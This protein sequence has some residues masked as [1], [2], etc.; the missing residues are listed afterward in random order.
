MRVIL[1]LR[2]WHYCFMLSRVWIVFLFSIYITY[3]KQ[4]NN[5]HKNIKYFPN[6]FQRPPLPLTLGIFWTKIHRLLG[7]MPLCTPYMGVNLRGESP[8]YMNP[9]PSSDDGNESTSRRQG[10]YR[11][12]LS[13][14]SRSAKLGADGQKVILDIT[15]WD[16]ESH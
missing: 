11:E 10:R 4:R 6:L 16:M 3:G 12:V 7:S 14:E 1:K 5:E 2:V 13:E 8:L 9:V 15:S